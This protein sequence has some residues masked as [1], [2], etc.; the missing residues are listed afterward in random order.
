MDFFNQNNGCGAFKWHKIAIIAD[1][2]ETIQFYIDE[3]EKPNELINFLLRNK[4]CIRDAL[5]LK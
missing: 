1:S 3:E 5:L 4:N 2:G